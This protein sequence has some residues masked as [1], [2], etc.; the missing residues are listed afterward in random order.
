MSSKKLTI[1]A[2]A[3]HPDDIEYSAGG[4]VAKY[5]KAGHKVVILNF[6]RGGM[7]TM[8]YTEEELKK[9]RT[10]EGI[11]GGKILGAAEVRY[12]D[13]N[14]YEDGR[15]CYPTQESIEDLVE[16]IRDVKPDIMLGQ[17]SLEVCPMDRAVGQIMC[18]AFTLCALPN[19]KTKHPWHSVTDVWMFGDIHRY[20]E[21]TP[22][23]IQ[24]LVYIDVTDTI[25][26]KIK[27]FL[28][29]KSQVQWALEH[30]GYDAG[31]GIGGPGEEIRAQAR[32]L[33]YLCGRRYAE[34]FVPLRPK[35]MDWFP[36][37][38]VEKSPS[39]FDTQ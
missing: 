7:G 39:P 34:A 17:H 21:L 5:A 24:H 19:L 33:G 8:R 12:M 10:Q 3:A 38:E 9:I 16:V 6:T 20:T 2:I 30:K 27:A 13:P 4:T 32:A 29:H 25:D 18:D 31:M 15:F 28:A 26:I 1:L 35:G 14:K 36:F 37:Y 23:G 22:W 11:E